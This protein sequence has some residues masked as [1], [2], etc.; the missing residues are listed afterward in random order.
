M[1]GPVD[2]HDPLGLAGRRVLVTGGAGGLGR[3][4][5]ETLLAHGASVVVCDVPG[6]RLESAAAELASYGDRAHAVALDLSVRENCTALPALACEAAGLDG[7]DVL[8]N[9]VGIM[10]TTPMLELAPEQW[11]RTLAINLSGVFATTQAA[12]ALMGDGASIVNVASVAARS[13][14]PNAVDYAA[15]KAA[16]LSL[17]KSA[18]LA[19]AP[20]VRVNAVCPGIFLTDMWAGIMRDR[21]EQFGPGAG[22]RYLQEQSARSALGRVGRPPELA[23]V[24]AFL[25]GPLSSFVT[26]Q[27]INVDGGLEMD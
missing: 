26:G 6:E 1:N 21:D 2:A 10:R 4:S 25:A 7:L 27:A 11:D 12:A 20:R 8:V 23:A 17:T 15:T 5:A 24:V 16:L 3:A 9:A 18:A 19:L 22:E 13:G 14:R